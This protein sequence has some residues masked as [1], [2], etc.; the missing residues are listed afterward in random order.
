MRSISSAIHGASTIVSGISVAKRV[1]TAER[2]GMGEDGTGTTQ[3]SA[4]VVSG[5][6]G[7]CFCGSSAVTAW[8][9]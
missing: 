3:A 1:Y 2:W 4:H 9:P 6:L 5:R 7:S 8:L